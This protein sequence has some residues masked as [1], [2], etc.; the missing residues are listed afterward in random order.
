MSKVSLIDKLRKKPIILLIVLLGVFFLKEVFLADLFPMFTGQDEARHYNTIQ[1]LAYPRLPQ[2]AM[3]APIEKQDKDRLETYNFSQEIKNTIVAEGLDANRENS[4]SQMDF[5]PDS[6]S[7]KNEAAIDA[8]K[9]MPVNATYPPDIASGGRSL[10]HKLA[11]F[12][13]K[14]LAGKSILVRFYAARLFSILLGTLAILFFYFTL[15]NFGFSEKAVLAITAIA[16]F[17]PRFSIYYTSVNYDALLILAFAAFAWAGSLILK[18]GANWKNLLALAAAAAIGYLAKATGIILIAALIF[19]IAF[20]F[21]Q[22]FGRIISGRKNKFLP[23]AVFAI[24]VFVILFFFGNY[25]PFEHMSFGKAFSSLGEYLGK[26]LTPGRLSLT[27]RTYWGALGWTDSAILDKVVGIIR[28]IELASLAGLVWF[29]FSKKIPEYLPEKKYVW[30]AIF[31]IAALQLGIRVADWKVFSE[32]GS[33]VLGTPGRYFIPNLALHIA[34]V[35]TGLGMLMRKKEWLE[36]SLALGAVLMF[37]FT[38]YLIF[39][40]IIFRFYL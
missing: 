22:K 19:L 38:A 1:Y 29:L 5:A 21:W 17:Q 4:F 10:Y 8:N 39:D 36:N 30:F 11:S 14:F 6:F 23:L 31:M 34:L 27:A 3:S 24:A 7:G 37:S 9:W 33:L 13:E 28:L 20:L 26:S 18:K 15:K 2:K 35:F 25:L 32:S 40:V 12:I 16:A